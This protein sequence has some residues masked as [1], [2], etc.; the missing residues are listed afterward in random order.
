MKSEDFAKR[1]RSA[2]RAGAGRPSSVFLRRSVSD[3]YDVEALI[4]SAE[5]TLQDI[6]VIQIDPLLSREIATLPSIK[7]R[8]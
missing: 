7:S 5:V 4:A 8:G 2:L 6:S 3:A 1:V